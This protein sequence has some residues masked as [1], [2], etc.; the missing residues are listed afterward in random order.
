MFNLNFTIC[1]KL[2]V[3]I[4]GFSKTDTVNRNGQ[5]VTFASEYHDELGT[6]PDGILG[7]FNV[8]DLKNKKNIY[9]DAFIE[10]EDA[11]YEFGCKRS[12]EGK[13]IDQAFSY[14]QRFW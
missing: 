1:H 5:F 4:L 8:D 14:A 11:S 13:G 2:F 3:D 7:Y 10:V 9:P 12:D 6:I